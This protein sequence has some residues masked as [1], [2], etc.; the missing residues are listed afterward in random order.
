ME[1]SQS[2]ILLGE[3]PTEIMPEIVD[4]VI[5]QFQTLLPDT[6]TPET[7]TVQ[8]RPD[9]IDGECFQNVRHQIE[10]FGGAQCYGWRV[11]LLPHIYIYGEFHAVWERLDG[12]LVDVSPVVPARQGNVVFIRDK[13]RIYEGRRIAHISA[14]LWDVIEVRAYLKVLKKV[15]CVDNAIYDAVLQGQNPILLCEQLNELRGELKEAWAS[16]R[17]AWNSYHKT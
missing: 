9:A 8:T 4:D 17:Q 7:I 2:G 11:N 6:D 3:T 1:L 5:R 16:L 10:E 14:V 13:R 12:Q 15:E